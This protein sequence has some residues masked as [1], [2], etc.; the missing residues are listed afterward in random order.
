MDGMG[1]VDS[2]HVIPVVPAF[3]LFFVTGPA[4]QVNQTERTGV[5]SAQ[6]VVI[7]IASEC[8]AVDFQIF[9][10]DNTLPCREPAPLAEVIESFVIIFPVNSL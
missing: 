9:T 1:V 2:A 5:D 3:E 7:I 8:V 4:V 6:L 10:I